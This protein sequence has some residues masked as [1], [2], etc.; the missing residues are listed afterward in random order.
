MRSL[1]CWMIIMSAA[2]AS[3]DNWPQWRGPTA[4]GVAA[5]GDYPIRFSSTT[6]VA[7]KVALPGRASSTPAVWNKHI[8]VTSPIDGKDGLLCFNRDG[9][10]RW[11][12]QF[13][14]QST[15]RH[16]AGSG[17]NPSP[18]TD[19]KR[20]FV[21]YKSGTI[22]ALDFK[23][24]VI[25]KDNLQ[26]RFGKNTLKFSLGTSPVLADKKVII[27]VMQEG[28]SYI[29]ALNQSTG[30]VEWKTKR[31]FE[32]PSENDQSYTTPIVIGGRK[33]KRILT[34]G[35]DHLTCHDASN[36]EVLW[37][38]EGF[39][40]EN[41]SRWRSI[42][43]AS[44][45]N[46]VLIISYARGKKLCGIDIQDGIEPAKRWLWKRDRVGA[47]SPTP[48]TVDGKVY[49]LEDAGKLVCLDVKTGETLWSSRAP[50]AGGR[51]YASPIVA[52]DNIYCASDKGVVVVGQLTDQFVNVATNRMNEQ[53]ISTVVPVDDKLIIRTAKHLFC[54]A[55]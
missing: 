20:A 8:F 14:P 23:G 29:V 36:G 51:Y 42:A 40:P 49:L 26:A 6:N 55:N 50:R 31:Q 12:V 15:G 5:S 13:G 37:V 17:S 33:Q 43:S 32:C 24:N 16:S 38:C 10:E 30:K 25:W 19:G 39:N 47:D 53:I 2:V 7:W 21:Y 1:V 34:W 3:A 22:A 52:G 54:I 28:D 27:A 44:I 11:R 48:A 45:W 35:A 18:I 4:T 41:N 9:K 46:N